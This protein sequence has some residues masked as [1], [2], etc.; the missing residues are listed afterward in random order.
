MI[1]DNHDYA[2]HKNLEIISSSRQFNSWVYEKVI[3]RLYGSVLE[4]GSGLGVFSEKIVRDMSRSEIMLTDKS[5]SYLRN[6]EKKFANRTNVTVYS[7][8]LECTTD[9]Q[10]IGYEKF[11]TI[12]AINVLE[13]VENDEFVFGQLYRMLRKNGTIILLVPSYK[14]L[15][16]HIDLAIGHKRRYTKKELQTKIQKCQ[17]IIEEIQSFNLAGILGWYVNGNLLQ[18]PTISTRAVTLFDHLVPFWKL[19]DYITLK[20]IGLSIICYLRRLD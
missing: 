14:F 3:G 6:L 5:F 17:F 4:V 10:K 9:Y 11:D 8:D 2:G 16:N 19:L 1:N 7:L 12:L 18:N 13:H 15:Y 20:K